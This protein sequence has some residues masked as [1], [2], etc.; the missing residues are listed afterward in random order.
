MKEVRPATWILLGVLALIIFAPIFFID[1]D[2]LKSTLDQ[3]KDNTIQ[4]TQTTRPTKTPENKAPAANDA[5]NSSESPPPA[6][7]A[8]GA[9]D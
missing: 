2:G 4:P 7:R 5:D 3:P 9:V 1:V 6:N 8:E